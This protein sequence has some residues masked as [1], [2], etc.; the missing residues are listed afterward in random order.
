MSKPS[1]FRAYGRNA[2]PINRQAANVMKSG[3]HWDVDLESKAAAML[4]QDIP[5]AVMPESFIGRDSYY[6]L[7]NYTGIQRGRLIAYGYYPPARKWACRCQCG[8]HVL[9]RSRALGNDKNTAD[10][11]LACQ[12]L[13]HLKREEHYRR[14]GRDTNREDYV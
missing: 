6:C 13:M 14:T 4:E 7:P 5:F 10:A 3:E 11:C 1:A 12:E 8:R 9:R 2:A